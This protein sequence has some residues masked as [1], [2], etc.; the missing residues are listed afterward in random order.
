[1]SSR[2]PKQD[3]PSS[4]GLPT[5]KEG[6]VSNAISN[7]VTPTKGHGARRNT[8]GHVGV[9]LHKPTGR[10]LAYVTLANGKRKNLKRHAT[11]AEAAAARTAYIAEYG[12]ADHAEVAMRGFD[13]VRASTGVFDTEVV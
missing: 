6:I 3:Q 8:S 10:W 12:V 9:S 11:A 2:N 1:M 5:R 7:A 4:P 13:A